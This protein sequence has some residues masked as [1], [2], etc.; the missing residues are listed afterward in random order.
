MLQSV[1][2]DLGFNSRSLSYI[3]SGDF[4]NSSGRNEIT[5]MSISMIISKPLFGNGIG[6]DLATIG[7]YTHN[8]FLDLLLH[9][10][11]VIGILLSIV[12]LC[13]LLIGLFRSNNKSI[14][15]LFF[16]AG[17]LPSMISGTYLSSVFLWLFLGYCFRHVRFMNIS[18]ISRK[19]TKNSLLIPSK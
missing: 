11:V 16:C 5:S 19:T 14:F 13:L 2:T 18:G 1:F 17:F 12:V 6:S 8:L 15:V 7:Q 9:Y 4:L 10:G 3:A